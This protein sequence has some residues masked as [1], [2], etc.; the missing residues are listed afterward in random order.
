[1]AG[2]G[3]EA[4]VAQAMQQRVDAGQVVSDAELGR[5][6]GADVLGA[7]GADAIGRGGSG[8]DPLA[9]AFDRPLGQARGLAGPGAVAQGVWPLGI[10]TGDPAL[11]GPP[12]WSEGRGDLGSGEGGGGREDGPESEGEAFIQLGDGPSAEFA[13]AQMVGDMHGRGSRGVALHRGRGKPRAQERA[14]TK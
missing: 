10:V 2:P 12:R 13:E 6:D 14:K 1:M 11:G 3:V 9:E 8:V 4:G 7:E 5:E